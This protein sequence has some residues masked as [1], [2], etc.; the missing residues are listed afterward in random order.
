MGFIIVLLFFLCCVLKTFGLAGLWN[1]ISVLFN[2]SSQIGKANFYFIQG[3]LYLWTP[4]QQ[5]RLPLFDPILKVCSPHLCRVSSAQKIF[6]SPH[7]LV[8]STGFRRS[9][10][11]PKATSRFFPK[12]SFWFQI[13]Y[14]SHFLYHLS[15]KELKEFRMVHKVPF[16]LLS[17]QLTTTQAAL[18]LL[19]IRCD[20]NIVNNN[21]SVR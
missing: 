7:S 6:Y 13:H 4:Y 5:I 11:V 1:D 2:E 15:S 16:L 21:N 20:I 18:S 14:F 3:P 8:A 10:W 17:S 9:A 12:K 19:W